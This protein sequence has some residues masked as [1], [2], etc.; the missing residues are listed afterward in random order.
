[1]KFVETTKATD[2]DVQAITA[3]ELEQVGASV[4]AVTFSNDDGDAVL[5]ITVTGSYSGI[6]VLV[7]APPTYKD[8][9]RVDGILAGVLLS[10][11]YA[12][13]YIADRRVR[14][15]AG[16]NESGDFRSTKV[17]V[18]EDVEVRTA[19]PSETPA[20]YDPDKAPF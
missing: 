15:L 17:K 8:A 20:E 1:M 4:K 12:D 13:S 10:E 9:Y 11:L 6:D 18:L 14:E 2:I 5:K 16:F 19:T 7:P 3:V